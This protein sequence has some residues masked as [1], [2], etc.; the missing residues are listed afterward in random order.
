MIIKPIPI[1]TPCCQRLAM[2]TTATVLHLDGYGAA[3]NESLK[4][5][6]ICPHCGSPVGRNEGERIRIFRME[7]YIFA[8]IPELI[9][10][11]DEKKC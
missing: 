8:G 5:Q 9:Y 11:D 6:T 10:A 7:R 4:R 2:R 3:L 1:R